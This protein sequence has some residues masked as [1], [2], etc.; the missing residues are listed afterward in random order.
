MFFHWRCASNLPL[1]FKS[2]VEGKNYPQRN[3]I[4]ARVA[5]LVGPSVEVALAT[6]NTVPGTEAGF[7]RTKDLGVCSV[8]RNL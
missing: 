4:F 2:Y 3:Y 5:V 7:T 6:A 8:A 1:D